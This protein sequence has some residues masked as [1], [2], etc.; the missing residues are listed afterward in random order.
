MYI[1]IFFLTMTSANLN[2]AKYEFLIHNRRPQN[3]YHIFFSTFLYKTTYIDIRK[4]F[5][6]YSYYPL[7]CL[8]LEEDNR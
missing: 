2:V 3:L 4:D 7:D 1:F 8:M 6:E 5:E